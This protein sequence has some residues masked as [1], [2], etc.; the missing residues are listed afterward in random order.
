MSPGRLQITKRITGDTAVT[1]VRSSSHSPRAACFLFRV[2]CASC[3][4]ID[5][6]ASLGWA[7]ALGR[8]LGQCP[9]N[10]IA[11]GKKGTCFS[12]FSECLARSQTDFQRVVLIGLIGCASL[13]TS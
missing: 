3:T 10:R 12:Q 2:H 6:Q 8:F 11:S 5:A 4:W 1:T 13:M 7:S 9:G